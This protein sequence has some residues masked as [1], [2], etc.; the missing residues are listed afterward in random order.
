MR[1][2]V[3]VVLA[4]AC[5]SKS[6]PPKPIASLPTDEAAR[7]CE[8]IASYRNAT[9]RMPA[10]VKVRCGRAAIIDSSTPAQTT[11]E[12]MRETCKLTL[13][14]CLDSPSAPETIDCASPAFMTKLAGC[15]DL[16]V[17]EVTAC[18]EELRTM[19]ATVAKVDP[20]AGTLDPKRPAAGLAEYTNQLRGPRCDVVD[21]KCTVTG[22]GAR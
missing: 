9:A 21:A 3:L 2:C 5:S 16:T 10:A 17:D 8:R 7:V 1:L 19:L 6:E 22:S 4:A 12:A 11:P 18:S 13:A 14:T 20:C 15:R